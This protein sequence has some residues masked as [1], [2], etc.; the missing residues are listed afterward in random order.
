MAC[1]P[2]YDGGTWRM[3]VR[4]RPPDVIVPFVS[5]DGCWRAGVQSLVAL[6]AVGTV[7]DEGGSVE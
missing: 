2:P 5:P 3:Y 6:D 7:E 4:S 1:V